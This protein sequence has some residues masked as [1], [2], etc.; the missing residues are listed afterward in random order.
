MSYIKHSFIDEMN[1]HITYE[2]IQIYHFSSIFSG[3]PL[4]FTLQN[5]IFDSL[6]TSSLVE[7][8]E[9]QCYR[10]DYE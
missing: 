5:Q 10:L 7:K 4:K 3:F 8:A 6:H 1:S 2:V 9:I